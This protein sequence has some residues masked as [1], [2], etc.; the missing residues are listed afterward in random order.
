MLPGFVA[1]GVP[2]ERAVAP[3]FAPVDT[4][5]NPIFRSADVSAGPDS[6]PVELTALIVVFGG[7]TSVFAREA[8][9]S[10]VVP[11]PSRRRATPHHWSVRWLAAVRGGRDDHRRG[12]PVGFTRHG[13]HRLPRHHRDLVELRIGYDH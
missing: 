5:L 3:L 7:L 12:N 6:S 10:A 9:D 13:V 1:D 8:Q 4:P 11:S 2:I